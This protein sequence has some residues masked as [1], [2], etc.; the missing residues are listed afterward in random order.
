[1]TQA[2]VLVVAENL[3]DARVCQLVLARQNFHTTISTTA[4]AALEYLI[5]HPVDLLLVDFCLSE[6]AS[7]DLVERSRLLCPEMAVVVTSDRGQLEPAIRALQRGVEGLVI[8]PFGD[9]EELQAA[10][11]QALALKRYRRDSAWL[12]AL[13][14]LFNT[15]ERLL[16][17]TSRETL[18][19]LVLDSFVEVLGTPWAGF[20]RFEQDRN[21]RPE[22][23]WNQCDAL[24]EWVEP[25][26]FFTRLT[27]NVVEPVL[28]VSQSLEDDL[29]RKTCEQAGIHSLIVIPVLRNSAKWFFIA[30]RSGAHQPFRETDVEMLAILARQAS[31][32]LENVN[33]TDELQNYTRQVEDSRQALI[34]TEKMAAVGRFI[35]SVAH[36]INNPL[37]GVA[38]C[39]HLAERDELSSEQRSA[40]LSMGKEELDR[41]IDSL[42]QMLDFYRSGSMTREKLDVE[43]IVQHVLNLLSPEIKLADIEIIQNIE[44]SP[45]QSVTGMRNQI[46]QVIMNI[47]LNAVD[48]VREN[49]SEKIIWIDARSDFEGLVIEIED[50]GP[51]VPQENSGKIFEPFFTTKVEGTGLGLVVCTRLVEAHGGS[52]NLMSPKYCQGSNF[53]I[54]IPYGSIHGR[55]TDPHR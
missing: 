28:F 13:H 53:V 22:L 16:S 3:L 52:L 18:V 14:P 40:Y 46:Q 4:S 2:E 23:F 6:A 1:M 20:I 34:Q 24:P 44:H 11:Q 50:N 32:A 38:N 19:H 30:C 35:A 17:E 25:V 54:R 21:E 29:L 10:A 51:G 8:K 37:Q 41:L 36:E 31:I 9:G 27:G 43:E 48:A 55:T 12:E 33:L 42:K 47:L 49:Q 39:L 26:D 45:N 5:H 7:F 15:S